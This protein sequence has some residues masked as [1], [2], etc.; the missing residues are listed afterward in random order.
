MKVKGVVE[1]VGGRSAGTGFHRGL[2]AAV[3]HTG[4]GRVGA[5]PSVRVTLTGPSP[6]VPPGRPAG[7]AAPTG[8]SG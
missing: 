4:A 8:A 1:V 3:Q 5:A 6:L 7:G 2:G